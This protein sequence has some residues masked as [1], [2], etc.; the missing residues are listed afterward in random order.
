MCINQSRQ[1]RTAAA[2]DHVCRCNCQFRPADLPNVAI[3]HQ[4]SA[5]FLHPLTIEDTHIAYKL[6]CSGYLGGCYCPRE[7]HQKHQRTAENVVLLDFDMQEDL[8]EGHKIR[9]AIAS[10][11]GIPKLQSGG[12]LEQS[13]HRISL[14]RPP[15]V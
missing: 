4:Y 13:V 6:D 1:E 11:R 5:V 7:Q 10:L 15:Y 2:V 8:D 12:V 3:P 9:L 14:E